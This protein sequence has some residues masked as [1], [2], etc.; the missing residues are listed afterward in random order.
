MF[1]FGKARSNFDTISKRRFF[2]FGKIANLW[3]SC[4]SAVSMFGYE[5]ANMSG[6]CFLVESGV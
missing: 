1:S 3:N 2:C 5:D 6:T 4:T